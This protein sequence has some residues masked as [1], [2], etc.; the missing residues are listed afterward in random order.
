MLSPSSKCLVALAFIVTLAWA[1]DTSRHRPVEAAESKAIEFLTREVPAWSKDNGCFSC[2]NNGDAARAL[3]AATRR[4]YRI[5]P[6][7]LADT[8]LWVSQPARWEQNKGDA[9][10]SDKRLADIQFAAS[11]VAAFESGY[12]TNRRALQEAAKKIVEG[13]GVD[14]AWQIDLGNTLGSPATYGTPL[15]TYMAL[16]VLKK[17]GSPEA[18]DAIRRAERWMREASPENVLTA[19]T[20]L[21]MSKAGEGE[22][23][24]A[25]QERCLDLIRRA[26]T[27]DGGWGPYADSPPECFDTAIVLLSLAQARDRSGVIDLIRRG[28]NFLAA[29]QNP[30][31]SWPETTRPSRGES[32][33]QRLSTTGWAT[34]ALLETRE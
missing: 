27:R 25:K 21:L 2:H 29:Q 1:N 18:A 16:S 24:L 17:S 6:Q 9:A 8:T 32:Y 4:G 30:D 5:A 15:A 19:A 10:F 28:R 12:V 20:L 11:L 33:A 22:S 14:G 3:Y 34:L 31:G 7:A 26:Q 13:Q 23:N